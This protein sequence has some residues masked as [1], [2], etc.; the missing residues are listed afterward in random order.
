MAGFDALAFH[1]HAIATPSHEG[2]DEMRRLLV[3]TLDDAGANPH[4]DATGNV[5]ATRGGGEP[6]LVLNSHVDTVPPHVPLERDDDVVRGR[7]ACDAK[8]PLAALIDAFLA[9]DPATIGG[10]VTLAVTPD[11]ETHSTGAAALT[12]RLNDS[13][14]ALQADGYIV[15]EPTGLDVCTAAKGRVE[16]KVTVRG[17]AAHAAEPGTGTDAIRV[18]AGLVAALDGFDDERGPGI[19]EQLGAPTLTVTTIDGGAATNQVAGECTFTVDRRSVPPETAASFRDAL[20]DY[21]GER[22]LDGDCG[23]SLT[24][25]DTPFLE[26]FATEPDARLVETLL[27]AGAGNPRPFTAATEASYFATDAPTVVFG[28]GVLADDDGAVAHAER[29]Y[30]RRQDVECAADILREAIPAFLSG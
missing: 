2:V 3:D 19:H 30:V 1:E 10:R 24:A 15:G 17:E 11:E 13:G 18:A 22:C 25:R 20:D 28:P 21:V 29:E 7:G 9:T 12:G 23:F 14:S 6:H 8:G 27:G 16:G 5:L 4:V 26:A